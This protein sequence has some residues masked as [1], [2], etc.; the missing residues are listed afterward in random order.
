MKT[1]RFK[2]KVI[3]NPM[4]TKIVIFNVIF[5]DLLGTDCLNEVRINIIIFDFVYLF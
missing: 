4:K 2:K 5:T 1:N 3:K